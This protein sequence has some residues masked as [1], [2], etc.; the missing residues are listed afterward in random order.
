M[1]EPTRYRYE[2]RIKELERELITLRQYRSIALD[3]YSAVVEVV[4]DGKLLNSAWVLRQFRSIL[5]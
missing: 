1:N 3:I 2:K 4:R 5:P